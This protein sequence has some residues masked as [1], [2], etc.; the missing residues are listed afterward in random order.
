VYIKE[1]NVA[2]RKFDFA[3]VDLKVKWINDE[4]NNKYLHYALPLYADK[5][6]EWWERTKDAD[7][8]LDL[9]ILYNDEPVGLIGLL[10]IDR[11]NKKAEY[12]VCLGE[13]SC[14]GKGVAKTASRLL[15]R[16]AF[17]ELGLNKVYLY[18]EE[19][20]IPAQKL[21]ES[22]GFRKEGLLIDDLIYN[23]RKVNRYVYGLLKEEATL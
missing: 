10:G 20:N 9:T 7:G 8:R 13:H 16:Y 2:I 6:T 11:V 14:K 21:F 4:K 5:T 15:V 19:E 22:L 17:E 1:N 12:Y 18:T 23:G 3:D